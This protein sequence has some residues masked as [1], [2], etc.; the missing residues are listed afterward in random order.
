MIHY[1]ENPA[2]T[3]SLLNSI[4]KKSGEIILLDYSKEGKIA[5]YFEWIIKLIDVGH[6]KAYYLEDLESIMIS[7]GYKIKF[8]EKFIIDKFWSGWIMIIRKYK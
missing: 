2:K 8:S 4:L 3:V 1:V 5:K 6:K 7:A